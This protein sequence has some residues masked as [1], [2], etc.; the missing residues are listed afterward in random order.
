MSISGGVSAGDSE[1]HAADFLVEL[2]PSWT[3][4]EPS[5]TAA[6]VVEAEIYVDCQHKHDHESMDQV[7]ARP[8]ARCATPRQAV[9]ALLTAARELASLGTTHPIDYWTSQTKD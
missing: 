8:P 6:W 3:Q 2:W 5:K 9:D 1:H 7:W 4:E